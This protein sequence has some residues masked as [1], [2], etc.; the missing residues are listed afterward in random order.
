MSPVVVSPPVGVHPARPLQRCSASG[1]S[2]EMGGQTTHQFTSRLHRSRETIE[3]DSIVI[4]C[5]T[6]PRTYLTAILLYYSCQTFLRARLN[7]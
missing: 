7:T 1:V 2:R 3:R 6:Q 5:A 4:V